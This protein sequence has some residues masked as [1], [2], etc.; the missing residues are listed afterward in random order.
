MIE[1]ILQK[2]MSRVS[3]F[4]NV[5]I[6]L[7]TFLFVVQFATGARQVPETAILHPVI[8]YLVVLCIAVYGVY[9]SGRITKPFDVAADSLPAL[10]FS[11][12]AML[13]GAEALW[14]RLMFVIVL[15]GTIVLMVLAGKA[16]GDDKNG[17][18]LG[19]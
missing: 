5:G 17:Q 4:V 19:S 11:A 18:T 6:A 9:R 16:G 2:L 3:N 7:V 8:A 14:I 10:A 15:V 1:Q 13:A 12:A